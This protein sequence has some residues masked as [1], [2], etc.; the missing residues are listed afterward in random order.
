MERRGFIKTGVMAGLGTA[1]SMQVLADS[2]EGLHRKK[3]KINSQ[4]FIGKAAEHTRFLYIADHSHGNPAASS[5]VLHNLETMA[6]AGIRH[7]ISEMTLPD[8]DDI[9][10]E[11]PELKRYASFEDKLQWMAR[12][13]DQNRP[14]LMEMIFELSRDQDLDGARS[15][16]LQYTKLLNAEL[17]LK[18][19]SFMKRIE[20]EPEGIRNE[21]FIKYCRENWRIE[22]SDE[23]EGRQVAE[24]NANIIIQCR[25][26]GVTPHFT[27]EWERANL[28]RAENIIKNFLGGAL[29]IFVRTLQREGISDTQRSDLLERIGILN[30]FGGGLRHAIEIEKDN[31]NLSPE[32]ERKRAR[33]FIDLAQGEKAVILWGG[34]HHSK[35]L[36]INEFLDYELG[37]TP[38]SRK[39]KIIGAY[40]SREYK[41]KLDDVVASRNGRTFPLRRY[42]H[43]AH[44]NY[45]ADTGEIEVTRRGQ[46]FFKLKH[47][48]RRQPVPEYP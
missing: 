22:G 39:T 47:A 35:L 36:D 44:I 15:R 10:A 25:R 48:R 46:E 32:T 24:N 40:A 3:I 45:M 43:E 16:I 23:D 30:E 28:I 8:M 29:D 41:K 12:K 1:F 17:F 38:A 26:L 34:G 33:K 27:G 6:E 42:I 20:H 7:F 4:N 2:A 21:R 5:V 37:Y 9:E 14:H 31:F 18:D 13:A 19:H 11:F